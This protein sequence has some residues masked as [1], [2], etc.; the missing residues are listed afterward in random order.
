MADHDFSAL[1]AKYPKVI[2]AMADTFT[3][4]QFI[5]ELARRYQTLYVEAL[6]S[7]RHHINRKAPAPF[8]MVHGRLARQLAEFPKLIRQTHKMVRSRDIFGRDNDCS[9]WAK[10]H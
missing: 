1:F 5:L 10:V 9:K 6:Y 3:S 8:L 2:S 7:Y 4:H